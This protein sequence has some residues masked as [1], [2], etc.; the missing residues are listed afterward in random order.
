MRVQPWRELFSEFGRL[1]PPFHETKKPAAVAGAGF[2][3]FF[4]MMS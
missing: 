2:A 4:A 1:D 3:I